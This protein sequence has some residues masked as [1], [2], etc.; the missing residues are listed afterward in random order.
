MIKKKKQ[1]NGLVIE[2]E[3][4]DVEISEFNQNNLPGVSKGGAL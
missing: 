2:P 4:S 3:E 1:H